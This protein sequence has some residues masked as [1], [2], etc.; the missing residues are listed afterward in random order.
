MYNKNVI[1]I[2]VE[3]WFHIL[4]S[5][6]VPSLHEWGT[7]EQRIN[8]SME[9]LLDLFRSQGIR[10]TFFWLGW[11]AERHQ[12]LVKKCQQEGHE[13]A[14]HGYAHLLAYKVGRKKFREDIIKAKKLLEDITGEPVRGF[15]APGFG[16]KD[17]TRWAFDIIKEAGY[18]YDSSVFPSSRGHGGLLQSPLEPH[19]IY[20]KAGPLVELG[21]SMIE[22]MGRRISFFGGGY[23]RL[24]PAFL[25]QW[26]I[27]KLHAAG[28]PL[29]VYVHPR[30]VDLDHPRLP[31]SLLR[32][33]KS[34][35]NLNKTMPKL[36]LLCNSY[37]YMTMTELADHIKEGKVG[38]Q[39]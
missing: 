26:G 11:S 12:Q 1:S 36:E 34:Y 14:S 4:D 30:E 7:L 16:I 33:F 6:V 22:V 23:L 32:R 21:M 10:V 29:I 8:S 35:V 18:E 9:L 38:P 17:N 28:R 5:P 24:A 2:D 13:I 37:S 31:L 39:L 27:R 19:M 3:E 25:I 15:R 20:T